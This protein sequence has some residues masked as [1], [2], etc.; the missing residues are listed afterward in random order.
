VPAHAPKV[1]STLGRPSESQLV[2]C[3]LLWHSSR[4][5]Y[6]LYTGVA[7]SM[8]PACI[9]SSNE[10]VMSFFIKALCA[11]G[12]S[13]FACGAWSAEGLADTA[14]NSFVYIANST[15]DKATS[16]YKCDVFSGTM[17][18]SACASIDS[19]AAG[20][21]TSG[22][23]SWLYAHGVAVSGNHLFV[24]SLTS[25]GTSWVQSCP[26]SSDGSI[27]KCATVYHAKT[28]KADSIAVVKTNTASYLYVGNGNKDIEKLLINDGVGTLS[29]QGK[30]YSGNSNGTDILTMTYSA[31]ISTLY[32]SEWLHTGY[33]RK[34]DVSSDANLSDCTV[35]QKYD[36]DIDS[37]TGIAQLYKPTGIAVLP[38]GGF[39][40]SVVKVRDDTSNNNVDEKWSVIYYISNNG[41][42]VTYKDKGAS[43]ANDLMYVQSNSDKYLYTAYS[44]VGVQVCDI[45]ASPYSNQNCINTGFTG[46]ATRLAL[47]PAQ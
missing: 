14:N 33:I 20:T 6:W 10:G 36:F 46:K 1:F 19:S 12:I 42:S 7:V 37:F 24:L 15:T 39:Y 34:C 27:G 9:N 43:I 35:V 18:F 29:D 26:I 25:G 45:T 23:A 4:K 41:N 16:L 40:T 30:V 13:G 47:Y 31:S 44:N 21:D 3:C 38:E 5:I 32:F 17:Q 8:W 22:N 2:Y 11:V 28:Y